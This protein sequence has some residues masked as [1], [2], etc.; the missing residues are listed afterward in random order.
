MSERLRR[1]E[2]SNLYLITPAR[3]VAGP[4]GEFL[5]AV[6]A[7][8][9]DIV[10]LREK[11]MEAKPL[12]EFCEIA[13]SRTEEADAL[14]IV[15]DRVDVAIAAG[16]DGVHLGQDDLP[17]K[18]ARAQAGRDF[19]I[20][21]ST[22]ANEE[23]LASNEDEADYIGVGPVFHPPTHPERRATGLDFV[24]FASNDARKPFFAI[25]G[26]DLDTLA[27]VVA[28]GASRVAVVRAL[29][30]SE[31][32]AGVTKRIKQALENR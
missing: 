25:G 1:L 14:F 18:I 31:D 8:G 19:L 16:A 13:R 7:A 3:P 6:L 32:P 11:E 29:T 17:P 28:A 15:N 4:L 10:Q 9:V 12:L 21:L 24:R 26:V 2:R 20:G 27:E 23:V 30:Q 22:H 5:A